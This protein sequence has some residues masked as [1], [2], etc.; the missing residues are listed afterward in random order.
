MHNTFFIIFQIGFVVCFGFIL[1]KWNDPTLA[2]NPEGF[3]GLLKTWLPTSKIWIPD[4]IVFN[5][6]VSFF[7]LFY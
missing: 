2:W 1:Q 3:G 6:F 4:I 7:C 5:M